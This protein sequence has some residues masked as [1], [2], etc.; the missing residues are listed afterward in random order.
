MVDALEAHGAE[1]PDRSSARILHEL[2]AHHLDRAIGVVR[3]QH[4]AGD[5]RG[6][7]THRGDD[8]TD[9]QGA[10]GTQL[11]VHVS[12]LVADL[13]L[14][15][16]GTA[17]AWALLAQ[18]VVGVQPA[19]VDDRTGDGHD[20]AHGANRPA[21]DLERSSIGERLLD[22]LVGARTDRPL[23]TH[24]A[25][26]AAAIVTTLLTSA[27]RLTH[28][29]AVHARVRGGANHLGAWIDRRCTLQR[30]LERTRLTRIHRYSHLSRDV[31]RRTERHLSAAKRKRDARCC[32][33]G[34]VDA[35]PGVLWFE[36][37]VHHRLARAQRRRRQVPRSVDQRAQVLRHPGGVVHL[38]H[39]LRCGDLPD[40]HPVLIGMG[41]VSTSDAHDQE[42]PVRLDSQLGAQ[43]VQ[44]GRAV[45][46]RLQ[47]LGVESSLSQN[48]PG[49]GEREILG[50]ELPLQVQL[51]R[52]LQARHVRAHLLQPV[53]GRH[54]D[55]HVLDRARVGTAGI[56]AHDQCRYDDYC[57]PHGDALLVSI[58]EKERNQLRPMSQ[59]PNWDVLL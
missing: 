11:A 7:A 48:R 40:H 10:S 31:P 6:N 8:P 2:K 30:D 52:L 54:H 14:G 21:G 16:V 4:M 59:S 41:S 37:E 15:E 28:A 19:A 25:V 42:V 44:T 22:A 47:P 5:G 29:A 38:V 13:L 58:H 3:T 43:I 36:F 12:R 20:H 51:D 57:L 39:V 26:P 35:H 17:V 24:A 50:R 53:S 46:A 55:E 27:L 45:R 33:S 34:P 1:E 32:E 9:Q 23:T 49:L 56:Q 18:R